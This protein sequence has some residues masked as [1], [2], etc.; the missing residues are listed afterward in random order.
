ML[1]TNPPLHT[2]EVQLQLCKSIINVNVC[3]KISHFW[4]GAA[5]PLPEVVAMAFSVLWLSRVGAGVWC[6]SYS[7]FIY[8]TQTRPPQNP[9]SIK[10]FPL[11]FSVLMHLAFPFCATITY[12]Y[13]LEFL[14]LPLQNV[15]FFSP[16]K[17]SVLLLPNTLLLAFNKRTFFSWILSIRHFIL[18]CIAIIVRA[19]VSARAL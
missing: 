15:L 2:A 16:A 13:G 17:T 6:L 8:Y 18:S 9:E 14:L 12:Y 4:W 10:P 19:E 1:H 3:W 7:T 11:A 5:W